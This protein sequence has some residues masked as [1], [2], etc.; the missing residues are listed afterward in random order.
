VLQS[1][2]VEGFATNIALVRLLISV[3]DLVAAECGRLAEAFATNLAHK[4]PR[5]CAQSWLLSF[6]ILV[7]VHYYNGNLI[8]SIS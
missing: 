5:S 3:D 4:R 1:V 2:P 8:P 7:V 6:S